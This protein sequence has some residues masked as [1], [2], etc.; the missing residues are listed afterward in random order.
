[1]RLYY[2][3][4]VLK[5]VLFIQT[6]PKGNRLNQDEAYEVSGYWITTM[7]KLVVRAGES[8][9]PTSSHTYP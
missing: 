9:A 4:L 1:M 6:T 8:H 2:A 5:E 7:K 3:E